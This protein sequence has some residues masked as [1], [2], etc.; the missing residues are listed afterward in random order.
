MLAG[1]GGAAQTLLPDIVSLELAHEA[2][3]RGRPWLTDA[4]TSYC[5]RC[6]A[7]MAPAAIT[8]AGCPWCHDQPVPWQRLVRLGPYAPPLDRWLL[9]MKYAGQWRWALWFGERLANDVP[10]PADPDVEP[11]VCPV[12]MSP[13]RRWR[14]GYNQARLMAEA[15]AQRRGWPMVQ[16][17]RRRG[18]RPPQASLEGRQ[19]YRNLAGIMRL[20]PVD[21]AG[22]HVVL[23]DDI[24]TT[25][26]TLRACGELLE[27]AGAAGLTV[28]VAAVAD[29][30]RAVRPQAVPAAAGK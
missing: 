5:P 20:G 24:K 10:A 2:R 7:T 1:L 16:L 17:L 8:D 12:P 18:G 23:V 11:V 15:L 28:A 13:M 26:T 27:H 22:I 6:G 4:A 9:A 14:R 21:L 30:T 19:R 3:A 25:G 29:P